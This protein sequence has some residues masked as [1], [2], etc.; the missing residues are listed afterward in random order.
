MVRYNYSIDI[1]E[2][3]VVIDTIT[4]SSGKEAYKKIQDTHPEKIKIT[5]STFNLYLTKRKSPFFIVKTSQYEKK[6]R[7]QLGKEY[8]AKQAEKMKAMEEELA[9][10]KSQN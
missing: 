3:N 2:D 4:A 9:Q 8:R 6:T 7:S 10:L 1:I 5:Y